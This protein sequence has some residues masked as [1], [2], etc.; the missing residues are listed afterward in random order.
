MEQ[1]SDSLPSFKEITNI[2]QPKRSGYV[3]IDGLWFKYRGRSIVVLIAFDT[4]TLDVLAY[5]ISLSES[6]DGWLKL[7]NKCGECLKKAKGFYIDGE[8]NLVRVMKNNFYDVPIQLCVFHKEIRIGQIIPLVRLKTEE[9]RWL[10]KIFETVLYD[11]SELRA[12]RYFLKLK[13]MKTFDPSEK[14]KMIFGVLNRNFD[15]LMTHHKHKGMH[16]TNNILEGFNGNISQKLDIM[17]GIKK[18][19]NIAR[20][21]KLIFLDYRFRKIQNSKFKKKNNLSP[22]EL[23]GCT[24][25]PTFYHWIEKHFSA[26]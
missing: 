14:K 21:L 4:E 20:Y 2:Y 6:E 16:R 10:K 8:L 18:P 17:R 3:G 9:E 5:H 11:R 22:L 25:V 13:I 12:L 15:L 26:T 23:S 19:L 24:N 1:I 7:I